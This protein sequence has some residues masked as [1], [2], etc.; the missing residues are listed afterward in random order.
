MLGINDSNKL[1]KKPPVYES[2]KESKIG[3]NILLITEFNEEFLARL[4]YLIIKVGLAQIEKREK[5]TKVSS[6]QTVV[7]DKKENPPMDKPKKGCNPKKGC[8][9]F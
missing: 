1:W 8:I 5:Q 4:S 7:K 6:K 3:E 9:L 2:V